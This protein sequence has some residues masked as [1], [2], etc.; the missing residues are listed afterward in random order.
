MTKQSK[1]TKALNEF[2]R[3]YIASNFDWRIYL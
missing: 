2:E 1:S 3:S